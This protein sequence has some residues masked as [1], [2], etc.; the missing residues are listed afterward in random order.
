MVTKFAATTAD[1]GHFFQ[2]PSS[3]VCLPIPD[4]CAQLFQ[5]HVWVS[6][7]TKY[8]T[9]SQCSSTYIGLLGMDFSF[10]DLSL[11]LLHDLAT[12]DTSF[13]IGSPKSA[14]PESLSYPFSST[15]WTS[16]LL[17]CIASLDIVWPFFSPIYVDSQYYTVAVVRDDVWWGRVQLVSGLDPKSLS[18]ISPI[19]YLIGS[20]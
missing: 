4:C 1:Q 20:I 16:S 11:W 6:S 7:C 2:N 19:L 14:A 10:W 13:S 3:P 15:S 12:P 8:F 18:F 17:S 9:V 5:L